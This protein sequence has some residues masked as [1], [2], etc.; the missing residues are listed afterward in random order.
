MK[1]IKTIMLSLGCM[2]TTGVRNIRPLSCE[3]CG[4]TVSVLGRD[5]ADSG[6]ALIGAMTIERA[7]RLYAGHAAEIKTHASCCR[8]E[9]GRWVRDHGKYIWIQEKVN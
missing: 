6:P 8:G 2:D 1:T 4:E 7:C 3:C 5:E 9:R